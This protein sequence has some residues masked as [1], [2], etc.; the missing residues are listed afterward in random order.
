MSFRVVGSALLLPVEKL[1][2]GVI[3]E[4][5][6]IAGKLTRFHDKRIHAR[7][8]RAGVSI[9]FNGDTLCLA[10][11]GADEPLETADATIRGSA[12]QLLK[13]LTDNERPLADRGIRIEG[14]AELLLDLRRTL[15]ELDLR[16]EDYLQPLLGDIATEGARSTAEAA[17]GWAR[18]A[19]SNIQRN[20]ANFAQYE[21]DIM[22]NPEEWARFA[23]RVDE[24]RL[25][26]DRLQARIERIQGERTASAQ[27]ERDPM[28]LP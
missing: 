9:F 23:E 24:L 20:V 22:P 8:R 27:P 1:L 4:N 15:V 6:H 17:V 18:Q 11:L 28:N 16:W 5:P 25:R 2:N 13:L 12:A 7:T 3:A 10:S 19:R 14:E 21:T 26:I